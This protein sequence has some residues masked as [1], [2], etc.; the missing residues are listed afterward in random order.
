MS[1]GVRSY[2]GPAALPADEWR[3]RAAC[4]DDDPDLFYPLGETW[5]AAAAEQAKAICARCPLDVVQACLAF[6]KRSNDNW[7]IYGG[8]TPDERA[9]RPLYVARPLTK[10]DPV[11]GSPYPMCPQN[12]LQDEDNLARYADGRRYCRVCKRER[13]RARAAAQRAASRELLVASC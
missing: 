13:A 4:R 3:D 5:T 11:P 9:G 2:H 6:A 10:A 8:Q 7:G 12:H 1:F